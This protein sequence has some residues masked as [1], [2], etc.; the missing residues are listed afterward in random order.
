M[1]SYHKS[2]S[3][4]FPFATTSVTQNLSSI[5]SFSFLSGRSPCWLSA[6]S[7]AWEPTSPYSSTLTIRCAPSLEIQTGLS[8]LTNPPLAPLVTVWW[9][10]CPTLLVF[11]LVSGRVLVA[12]GPQV[13]WLALSAQIQLC[14]FWF[15]R[16]TTSDHTELPPWAVW[17]PR[18][19][20][21][22]V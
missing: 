22:L 11:A 8:G 13:V 4:I 18:K 3:S 10:H 16:R 20:L 6:R 14:W 1:I 2:N 5:S 9:T 17:F 7:P 21:T 15:L 12:F 19:G